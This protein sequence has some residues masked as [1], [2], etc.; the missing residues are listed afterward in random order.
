MHDGDYEFSDP[1]GADRSLDCLD[2]S[3]LKYVLVNKSVQP[4]FLIKIGNKPPYN[5]KPYFKINIHGIQYGTY[6]EIQ[7]FVAQSCSSLCHHKYIDKCTD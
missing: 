2:E 5:Q 3:M 6:L 4:W 1:K 7:S